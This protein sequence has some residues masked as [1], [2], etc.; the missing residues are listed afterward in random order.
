VVRHQLEQ[1][2]LREQ[3]LDKDMEE[4]LKVLNLEMD[5]NNSSLKELIL[6]SELLV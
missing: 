6:G 4:A 1:E 2:W 3:G 5:P